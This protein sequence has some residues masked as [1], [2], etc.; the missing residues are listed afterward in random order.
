MI[1]SRGKSQSRNLNVQ[2][3]AAEKLAQCPPEMF[4][5]IL[6]ENQLED[7][8]EHIADYLEMYWKAT[9]PPVPPAK[10]TTT[11]PQP[12]LPMVTVGGARGPGSITPGP[13]SAGGGGGGGGGSSGGSAGPGSNASPSHQPADQHHHHSTGRLAGSRNMPSPPGILTTSLRRQAT[14]RPTYVRQRSKKK[15]VAF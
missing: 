3:V 1:K 13:S 6:D 8:C 10:P 7:A 4:D 15:S 14:V 12:S 11:T 9:H 5:I 2:M